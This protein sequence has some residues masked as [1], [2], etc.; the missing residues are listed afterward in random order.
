VYDVVVYGSTPAGIAAAISAGRGGSRVALLEPTSYLGG[1][2]VAGG[3]G[4]RDLG[5]NGTLG[6]I[7]WEWIQL[8]S[9]YYGVSSPVYQPDMDV[10][11]TNFLKLLNAVPVDLF[12]NS[13]LRE[14]ATVKKSGTKI[15]S[16]YTQNATGS[17]EWQAKVFFD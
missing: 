1:M 9:Q 6:G 15:L 13:P 3:I 4:L 7:G 10:G 2:A 17:L 11:N 16:I 14:S 5:V 12:Y 8:N